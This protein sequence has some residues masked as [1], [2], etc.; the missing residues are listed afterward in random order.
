MEMDNINVPVFAVN[1]AIKTSDWET[2]V[3]IIK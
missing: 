3:L 2:I 1:D